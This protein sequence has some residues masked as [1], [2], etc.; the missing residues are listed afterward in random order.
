MCG[1]AAEAMVGKEGCGGGG[2]GC[3]VCGE[4]RGQDSVRVVVRVVVR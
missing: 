1:G 4:K 2:G 3:G